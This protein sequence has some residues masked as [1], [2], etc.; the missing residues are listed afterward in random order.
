MNKYRTL[1][2]IFHEEGERAALEIYQQRLNSEASYQFPFSIQDHPCFVFP[3][4]EINAAMDSIHKKNAK[5]HFLMNDLPYASVLLIDS[6][7][8]EIEMSNEIEGIHSSRRELREVLG[9]SMQ[10]KSRFAG[11][12]SQYMKLISDTP[13]PF[14]KNPEEIR[15]IYDEM[16]LDEVIENDAKNQ[17]D[18]IYF[19]TNPVYVVDGRGTRHTGVLPEE[20][21]IEMLNQALGM[22]SDSEL[23]GLIK[24]AV[25]HF[26][27]GYIHPFYDGNGRMSRYLS[28]VGL[29]QD[30]G[31]PAAMHISLAL[32]EKR[33][34]YY[35]SFEACEHEL[36][37]SDLTPFVI[38]FLKA[39]DDALQHE[40]D[41]L[42]DKK[43]NLNNYQTKIKKMTK[44]KSTAESDFLNLLAFYTLFS[45]DGARKKEIA[46]QLEKNENSV[47][48]LIKKYQKYIF[49]RQE[50]RFKNYM[51]KDTF[52]SDN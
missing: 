8:T 21:I 39:L 12:V 5:L 35:K 15:K 45:T 46:R 26:I 13:H 44:E 41:L 51:L 29:M 27:F 3:C 19:R 31:M 24:I 32:R 9:I 47:N 38:F 14:P 36:N 37:Y 17:P 43:M 42:E 48:N 2:S 22:M 49:S 10:A 18:G 11:M 28:A 25:F 7:L 33:S 16:F 23:P 1:K 50:G 52:L 6:L 20:K 40:I 34:Q 4:K 30:L